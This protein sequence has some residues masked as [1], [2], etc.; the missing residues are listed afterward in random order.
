MKFRITGAGW[1]LGVALC[2]AG[3]IVDFDN[4]SDQWTRV[5]QGKVPFDAVPLDESAWRAQLE[6][7]GEHRH[8]LGGGWSGCE[9]IN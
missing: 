9:Q 5:A 2:P 4:K 1:Q 6:V 3:T 8:L 7:F